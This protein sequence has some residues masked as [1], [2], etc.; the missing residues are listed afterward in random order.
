[1]RP[2]VMIRERKLAALGTRVK[3]A[4]SG[5]RTTERKEPLKSYL[6]RGRFALF[7]RLLFVVHLRQLRAAA[8][9]G[10]QRP[11]SQES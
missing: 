11:Q 5:L 1:M 7:A 6:E 3:H 9:L 8:L 10:E 2:H 4:R